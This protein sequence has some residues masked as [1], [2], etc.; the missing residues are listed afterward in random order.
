MGA[1]ARDIT[2][3]G[4][5]AMSAQAINGRVATGLT[6]TGTV[7]TDA[8]D[9]NATVNVVSTTASGTGV[10]LYS[11]QIGDEMEVYNGGANALKV[12]PDS[13]TVGINQ[14]SV[15]TAVSLSANVGCKFR[16]VSATQ[17]IAY[18]SA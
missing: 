10:Q 14:L 5:S 17:I 4:T 13:S 1:L 2:T 12:Y 8:L 6:A 3:G 11:M 15:G 16:K 18:L 7:I 9:L